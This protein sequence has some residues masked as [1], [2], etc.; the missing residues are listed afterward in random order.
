MEETKAEGYYDGFDDGFNA[1]FAK[2]FEEAKHA[3]ARET[4]KLI[5]ETDID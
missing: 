4:A 3:I 2:G 5:K 1:G